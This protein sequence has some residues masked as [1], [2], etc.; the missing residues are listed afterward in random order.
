MVAKNERGGGG[1]A[2]PTVRMVEGW[3]F[4]NDGFNFRRNPPEG[5][6]VMGVGVGGSVW[7]GFIS[8]GGRRNSKNGAFSLKK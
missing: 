4:P 3:L 5:C 7:G 1:G 6:G 2:A 8:C